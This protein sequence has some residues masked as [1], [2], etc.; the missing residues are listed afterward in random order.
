MYTRPMTLPAPLWTAWKVWPMLL[1]LPNTMTAMNSSTGSLTPLVLE[2][3]TFGST[4]GWTSTT[5]FCPRGNSPGLLT[6]DMLMD[7]KYLSLL[8]FAYTYW[9]CC[10][11]LT[12]SSDAGCVVR[13]ILDLWFT[14][15][16]H[17]VY[18]FTLAMTYIRVN[19]FRIKI[20]ILP[21]SKYL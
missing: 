7:G 10:G 13:H 8:A 19:I 9:G 15:G 14:L 16:N 4:P 1:G 21:W 5:Q 12:L 2:S 3:H 20:A 11:L 17:Y 18:R 6:R